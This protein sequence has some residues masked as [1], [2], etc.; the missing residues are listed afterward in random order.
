MTEVIHCIGQCWVGSIEEQEELMPSSISYT[1][2]HTQA[3]FWNTQIK[4]LPSSCLSSS[5]SVLPGIL[6]VHI[7]IQSL[8]CFSLCL[9]ISLSKPFLDSSSKIQ[10]PVSGTSHFLSYSYL[11]ACLTS[12]LRY[13]NKS[14]T[15]GSTS[16]CFCMLH[17]L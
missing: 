2:S 11:C 17:V 4:P 6:S 1:T 7:H 5:L 10:S 16:H 15:G 14:A 8:P 12:S 3:N 9:H 13:N